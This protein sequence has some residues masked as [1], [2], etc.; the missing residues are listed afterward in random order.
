MLLPLLEVVY[1]WLTSFFGWEM[2]VS[3][4]KKNISFVRVFHLLVR[5]GYTDTVQ[6]SKWTTKW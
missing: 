6:S 3:S 2:I 5:V 4:K 1:M